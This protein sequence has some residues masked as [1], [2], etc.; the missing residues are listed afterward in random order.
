LPKRLAV[1]FFDVIFLTRLSIIQKRTMATYTN[2]GAV[3]KNIRPGAKRA[4]AE[5]RPNRQSKTIANFMVMI[6]LLFGWD[7]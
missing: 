7:G 2:T 1:G 4:N 3:K 5:Y 6:S